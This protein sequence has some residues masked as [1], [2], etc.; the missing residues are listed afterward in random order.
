[1]RPPRPPLI[2][3]SHNPFTPSVALWQHFVLPGRQRASSAVAAPASLPFVRR[4]FDVPRKDA[5]RANASKPNDSR[6]PRPRLYRA[7]NAW[8][9][10]DP[11][12]PESLLART[13][14]EVKLNGDYEGV[15][16]QPRTA[17]SRKNFPWVLQ[18]PPGGGNNVAAMQKYVLCP[19]SLARHL[20]L[21][22]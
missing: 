9:E 5:S 3:R 17:G 10:T 16:V 19:G 11:K 21:T 22:S 6:D 4:V 20:M 7:R 14:S 1:M 18:L 2:C 8:A 13:Q 12:S 15:V